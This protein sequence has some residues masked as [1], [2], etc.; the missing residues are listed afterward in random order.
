MRF[1]RW[2]GA[3]AM[4]GGFLWAL[5]AV[6]HSAEPE[7]CI[8]LECKDVPLP[9]AIDIVD[10][11]TQASVLL[12]LA[13]LA[14]LVVLVRQEGRLGK[15]GTVGAVLAM[16]GTGLLLVSGFSA[17]AFPDDDLPWI[18]FLVA[19]GLVA[20]VVGVIL[21][22]VAVLRSEVLPRR[23]GMLLIAGSLVL[24]ASNE[25]TAAALFSVPFGLAWIAVG[26]LMWAWTSPPGKRVLPIDPA[27]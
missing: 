1:V 7:T 8:G 11:M 21:L 23:S 13:G 2:C 20:A 10:V 6:M 16:L 14:G 17:A 4:L 9:A 15:P 12:L 3:A 27:G 18:P 5:T 26:N 25:R 22:G 19:P 24:F